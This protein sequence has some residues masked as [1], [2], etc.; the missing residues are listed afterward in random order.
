MAEGEPRDHD[1]LSK[2]PDSKVL[3][4]SDADLIANPSAQDKRL[5]EV[6]RSNQ[7]SGSIA[8][9]NFIL[10]SLFA[11]SFIGKNLTRSNIASA[12]GGH[13]SGVR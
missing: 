4:S 8:E 9:L 10:L 7:S 12:Y 13:L 2:V 11:R 6:D 3:T 1:R 5:F